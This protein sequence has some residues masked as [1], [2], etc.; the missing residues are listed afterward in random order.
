MNEDS[1][2]DSV[3]PILRTR[4]EIEDLKREWMMDSIW[5]IENTEGFEAHH[6]ELLAFSL[7]M[8]KYWNQKRA[9]RKAACD[10][11]TQELANGLQCSFAVARQIEILQLDVQQLKLEL[12]ER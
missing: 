9:E 2:P 7:E 8:C 10:R 3:T 12:S 4:E 1:T 11:E 6:D 5:D